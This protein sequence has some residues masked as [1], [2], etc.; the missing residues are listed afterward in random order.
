MVLM[1]L[2][3]TAAQDQTIIKK[4]A[5][6]VHSCM[7]LTESHHHYGP[8][9]NNHAKNSTKGS[10]LHGTDESHHNCFPRSN[11]HKKNSTKGSYLYGTDESHHNCCPRSN[12]H[13]KNSTK[14]SHLYGTDESHHHCGPRSN[15]HKK[16]ALKVHSCMELLNFII[17]AA[18]VQTIIIKTA[19]KVHSM[20]LMT[21][22]TGVQDQTIIKNRHKKFTPAWY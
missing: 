20:V 5:L 11:N 13:K 1:N 7:A 19:L 10:L 21:I 4:P 8:R 9:S 2:I 17:T 14:G 15:N 22:I 3:I 12:N 16:T 18:Q 6:K